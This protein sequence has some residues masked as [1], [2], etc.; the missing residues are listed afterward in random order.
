M[1]NKTNKNILKELTKKL[2]DLRSDRSR[3]AH[4]IRLVKEKIADLYAMSNNRA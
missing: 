4:R 2:S 1:L 3:N